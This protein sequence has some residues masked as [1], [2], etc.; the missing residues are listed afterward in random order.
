M[1][2]SQL[3]SWAKKNNKFLK[4]K[5]GESFKGILKDAKPRVSSFD[6]EKEVISY[7]FENQEGIKYFDNGSP[8]LAER[9]SAFIGKEVTLTRRGEGT[10]TKYEVKSSADQE[11]WDKNL[12]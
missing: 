3:E 10:T 9:L 2:K 5:D 4:L 6:R 7:A 12:G 11:E 8:A 1:D